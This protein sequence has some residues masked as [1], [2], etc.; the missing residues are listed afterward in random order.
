MFI[1]SYVLNTGIQECAENKP[2]FEDTDFLTELIIKHENEDIGN[3]II[4]Q[5]PIYKVLYAATYI[6]MI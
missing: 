3:S 4:H 5:Y 1:Y 2:V 6:K